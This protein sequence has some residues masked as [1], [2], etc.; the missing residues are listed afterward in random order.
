MRRE[1]SVSSGYGLASRTRRGASLYLLGFLLSVAVAPHRHL[2]S[3]E[4]LLSDGPSDS[5]VFVASPIGAPE[6]GGC[7]S[8]SRL[9]DDDPCLACFH[10]DYSASFGSSFHFSVSLGL[11]PA[12]F[13]PLERSLF[14]LTPALAKAAIRA[15]PSESSAPR[16]PP[17]PAQLS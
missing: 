16:S 15:P 4:D 8:S 11:S 17:S 2:N 9:I 6:S 14:P 10:H 3:L 12:S 1:V 5:G 13:L 7:L